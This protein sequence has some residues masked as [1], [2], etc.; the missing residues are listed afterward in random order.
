MGI[1]AESLKLTTL[2]HVQRIAL[3]VEELLFTASDGLSAK[4]MTV[5][6]LPSS[7]FLSIREISDLSSEL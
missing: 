3:P 7:V 5:P 1:N 4:Q 6:V 2:F